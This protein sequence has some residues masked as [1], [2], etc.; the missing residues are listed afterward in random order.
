[1]KNCRVGFASLAHGHVSAIR[2][3]NHGQSGLTYHFS[4]DRDDQQN[5]ADTENMSLLA[6]MGG[7]SDLVRLSFAAESFLAP[8]TG[9]AVDQ[10]GLMVEVGIG[11]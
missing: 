11:R 10:Q 9:G 8:Y 6:Q 3:N 7:K 5:F 4:Y 1:M 2:G